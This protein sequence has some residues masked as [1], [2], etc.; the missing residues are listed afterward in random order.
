[1]IAKRIG[2]KRGMTSSRTD[3]GLAA[4]LCPIDPVSRTVYRP[5]ELVQ[6]DVCKLKLLVTGLVCVGI[7]MLALAGG[8]WQVTLVKI[9]GYRA[10][11]R[12]VRTSKALPWAVAQAGSVRTL[13]RT[14]QDRPRLLTV[15]PPAE[16]CHVGWPG[17]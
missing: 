14:R 16:H 13:L 1:M 7:G 10:T 3:P 11:S 17:G 8:R 2:C 4:G 5:V 12:F 6:R 9:V 15:K